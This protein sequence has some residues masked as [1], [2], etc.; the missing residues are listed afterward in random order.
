MGLALTSNTHLTLKFRKQSILKGWAYLFNL[1]NH[2]T[3]QPPNSHKPCMHFKVHT[4]MNT[5][6]L[7]QSDS[8]TLQGGKGQT[9]QATG[10]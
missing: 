1:K 5:L 9:Q 2:T 6:D 8:I 10:F 3:Q 7:L 4:G